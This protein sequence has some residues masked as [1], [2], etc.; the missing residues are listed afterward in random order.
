MSSVALPLFI[1][2]ALLV[3]FATAQTDNGNECSCFLTNDSTAAYFTYHRFWD[4]RNI[5]APLSTEPDVLIDPTLTL[6]AGPTSSYFT[7]ELWTQDWT[8]Q[9]WNNSD[10]M[11]A[12]GATVLMI[13]SLNNVYIRG[14]FYFIFYNTI[15][16]TSF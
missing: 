7:N 13:N 2:C 9:A 10:S 12:D 16:L 5:A 6:N 4:F 3:S 11:S 14:F 15:P 8:L 1:F